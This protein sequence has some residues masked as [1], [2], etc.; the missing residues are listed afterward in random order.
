MSGKGF[1]KDLIKIGV[2][3]TKKVLS[4]VLIAILMFTTA[5][6]GS[7]NDSEMIPDKRGIDPATIKA[8]DSYSQPKGKYIYFDTFLTIIDKYANDNHFTMSIKPEDASGNYYLSTW[9]SEATGCEYDISC[10]KSGDY[11]L[12]LSIDMK[13]LTGTTAQAEYTNLCEAFTNALDDFNEDGIY[14]SLSFY[15][16]DSTKGGKCATDNWNYELLITD[17]ADERYAMFVVKHLFLGDES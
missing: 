3:T 5:C 14:R 4:I 15:A 10:H 8:D 9:T 16:L 13:N 1:K 11:L 7:G 6:S 12:N 2:I 17:L